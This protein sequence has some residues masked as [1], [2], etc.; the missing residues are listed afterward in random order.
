[1]ITTPYTPER[2]RIAKWKTW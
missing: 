1:V 2:N